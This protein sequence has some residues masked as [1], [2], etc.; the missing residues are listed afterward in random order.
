T[1]LVEI[2]Q[3]RLPALITDLARDSV[4]A[5]PQTAA[6]VEQRVAQEG[7]S[8]DLTFAGELKMQ[9]DDGH[10]RLELGALYAAAL[11]RAM[12]GR[13]RHGRPYELRGRGSSLN[14]R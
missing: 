10:V 13:I 9:V 4:L 6:E 2:L 5:D 11:P 14:L 7:S 12:R 1:G 3:K 8:E